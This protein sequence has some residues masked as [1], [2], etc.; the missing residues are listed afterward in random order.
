MTEKTTETVLKLPATL[1]IKDVPALIKTASAIKTSNGDVELDCSDVT[2]IDPLGLTVLASTIESLD[3]SR[4]VSMPWL[5]VKIASYLNRMDF[6]ARRE[7]HGV[8]IPTHQRDD[9]RHHLMEITVLRDHAA[10]EEVAERLA[11][12]IVGMI[13]NRAPK[14]VDFNNPDVEFNQYYDPIRY[15]ISELVENAL[16]HARREGRFAASVWIAAQFYKP[17]KVQIAVVDDGC[18]FLATLRNHPE[19]PEPT[20]S[21]AIVTALKPKISCNRDAGPFA[22]SVNQGVGL[23]TT[24]KI[25]TT[26]S[27]EIYIA[28]GDSLYVDG[29]D[30]TTKRHER[31][32]ALGTI[33]NGVAISAVFNRE[34]LSSVEIP[35][36]LPSDEI[37][38][39]GISPAIALRFED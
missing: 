7:I 10:A 32:H 24:A 36:L 25:A 34:K 4:R 13:V 1:G 14:P 19:L 39:A 27:G 28:S 11:N 3:D 16:T 8:E 35:K 26:S 2:F 38:G 21:A 22:P 33:W 12:A 6:F 15:A 5:S 29:T 23:T 30:P 37:R 9:L 17:N 31:I 18:G 20:H